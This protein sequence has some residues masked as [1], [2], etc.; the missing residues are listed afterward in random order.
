MLI[1]PSSLPRDS[2]QSGKKLATQ[3]DT[4]QMVKVNLQKYRA[5]SLARSGIA[6]TRKS[7]KVGLDYR[8]RRLINM[9]MR[10]GSARLST[11]R[12]Q[13]NNG[14]HLNNHLVV[15]HLRVTHGITNDHYKAHSHHHRS[16]VVGR[17]R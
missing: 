7:L 16:T 13:M 17:L 9:T 10:A 11:E 14:T 3:R 2:S 12:Q 1:N 15:E 6:L 8:T 4:P 5:I